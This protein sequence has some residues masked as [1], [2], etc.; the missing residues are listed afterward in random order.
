MQS[1]WIFEGTLEQWNATQSR[2]Y[3]I[4]DTYTTESGEKKPR[5]MRIAVDEAGKRVALENVM[6]DC[7]VTFIYPETA[8]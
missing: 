2:S 5:A 4:V 1:K 3:Q 6:E 8:S 7:T